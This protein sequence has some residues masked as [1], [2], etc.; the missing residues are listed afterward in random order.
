MKRLKFNRTPRE[1][2]YR[3]LPT[4]TTLNGAKIS[5][6]ERAGAKAAQEAEVNLIN[7]TYLERTRHMYDS[8]SSELGTY[9]T[10][11]R[12]HSVHIRQ[13]VE[14]TRHI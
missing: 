9:E 6:E 1:Q 2:T 10:D 12:A 5:E 3:L 8:Q 13:S 7:L 11:S 14:R 4:L